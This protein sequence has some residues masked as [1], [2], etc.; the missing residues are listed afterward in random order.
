[1]YQSSII[2]ET[3]VQAMGY[4]STSYGGEVSDELLEGYLDIVGEEECKKSFSDED[5]ILPNGILSSQ[6]CAGD[7]SRQRDTW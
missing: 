5:D 6:I 4:G 2:N 1:M 3:I 7:K